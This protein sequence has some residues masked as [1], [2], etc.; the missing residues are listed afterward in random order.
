MERCVGAEVIIVYQLVAF[1]A[2]VLHLHTHTQ[3]VC[4]YTKIYICDIFKLMCV[5]T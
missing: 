5:H 3:C 2:E 4:V 1:I